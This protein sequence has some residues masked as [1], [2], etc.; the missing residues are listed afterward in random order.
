MVAAADPAD[1]PLTVK[2]GRVRDQI[3]ELCRALQGLKCTSL[4]LNGAPGWRGWIEA[5]GDAGQDN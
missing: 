2:Q 4:S 1:G 5:P 3:Q